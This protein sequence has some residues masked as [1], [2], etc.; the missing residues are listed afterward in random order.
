VIYRSAIGVVIAAFLAGCASVP[1]ESRYIEPVEGIS[2][3]TVIPYGNT[4]TGMRCLI[5]FANPVCRTSLDAIGNKKLPLIFKP[6]RVNPGKHRVQIGC[7]YRSTSV[8]SGAESE[9]VWEMQSV[10]VEF[11]QGKT[12]Y[13][14]GKMDSI[15]C[16]P[17]ISE[18]ENGS[19]LTVSQ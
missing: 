10:N 2:S 12:Y 17:H 3:A 15:R 8:Q 16:V 1:K 18:T 5:V 11:K 13:V 9:A 19:R 4:L 6:I 7:L 14:F